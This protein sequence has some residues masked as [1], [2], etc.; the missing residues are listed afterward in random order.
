M[1]K[2]NVRN[3]SEADISAGLFRHHKNIPVYVPDMAFVGARKAGNSGGVITQPVEIG[4][5]PSAIVKAIGL[6]DAPRNPW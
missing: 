3:G 6:G 4:S 2:S 5:A 1:D